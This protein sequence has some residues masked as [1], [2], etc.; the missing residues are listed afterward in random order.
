[1]DVDADRAAA[2]FEHLWRQLIAD[3]PERFWRRL[4]Y[5]VVAFVSE[6]PAPSLNGVYVFRNDVDVL[7][8]RTLLTEVSQANVPFCLQARP[9]LRSSL[10]VVVDELGMVP[11][12]DVPLM[13][14]EDPQALRTAMEIDGM[15]VRQL[16]QHEQAVH[17]TLFAAGFEMPP[18]MAHAVMQLFGDARG[19]RE[20]VGEVGGTAV[21]TAVTVPSADSSVAVFNVSTPPEQRGKGYGGA[22]TAAAVLDGLDQGA[23]FA[24]LQSSVLGYELYQSLG[25]RAVE[26]WPVWVAPSGQAAPLH[27]VGR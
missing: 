6:I 7:A 22:V 15:R 18:E 26:S 16:A 13:V 21:T 9:A 11:D 8:V 27:G 17:E 20:F 2:S 10:A 12:E 19:L 24:W 25:F 1:M 23:T 5:G 4:E 3:A 14:L